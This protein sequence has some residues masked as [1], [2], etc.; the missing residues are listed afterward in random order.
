MNLFETN[1]MIANLII[2][3]ILNKIFRYVKKRKNSYGFWK[4]NEFIWNGQDDRL[5]DYLLD[6]F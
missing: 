4:I 1:K 3:E 6:N 5:P 2:F